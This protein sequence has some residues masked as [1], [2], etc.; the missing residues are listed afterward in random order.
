MRNAD[1]KRGR[2]KQRCDG[3]R[4]RGVVAQQ[5]RADMRSR[6][7]SRLA[8]GRGSALRGFPFIKNTNMYIYYCH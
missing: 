5:R 7:R 4:R 3:T 8:A 2:Y 6:G 1:R